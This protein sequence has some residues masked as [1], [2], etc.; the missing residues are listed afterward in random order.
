ML[1]FL[2]LI[3]SSLLALALI[4]FIV[5]FGAPMFTGAPF[6]VSSRYKINKML[7]FILAAV[8]GRKGLTA[9]DLGSGDGR[10]VIALAQ[11]GFIAYG[12]E[13]NPFLVWFSRLKIKLAGLRGKAFIKRANFWQED[14]SKYDVVVLFG[15][16]YIMERLEK[17][18]LAELNPGAIV[19]C[20]HFYFPAWQPVKQEG[21]IYIYRKD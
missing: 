15:V 5:T 17:K 10:I 13:I 9:A 3:F 1:F 16:F 6:A 11:N 18:L 19:V 20:N 12:L 14:F 21:D 7:P 8:A 2:Y 4:I